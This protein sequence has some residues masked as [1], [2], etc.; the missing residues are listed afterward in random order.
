[1]LL[2]V[3]DTV[4]DW[5]EETLSS[6]SATLMSVVQLSV[7]TA[8]K[9]DLFTYSDPDDIESLVEAMQLVEGRSF[10]YS[11]AGTTFYASRV[12]TNDVKMNGANFTVSSSLKG[13]ALMY[14]IFRATC[15]P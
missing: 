2:E 12:D 4:Q 3:I 14:P 8:M 5:E 1:M 6:P 15:T 7:V 10:N 11:A 9:Y 13:T